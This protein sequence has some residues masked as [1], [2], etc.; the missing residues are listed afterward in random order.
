MASLHKWK[1][2]R[3]F[4]Y[5]KNYMDKQIRKKD[6]VKIRR[7][8]ISN[9]FT[10]EALNQYINI[11]NFVIKDSTNERFQK[12]SL[13]ATREQSKGGGSKAMFIY[14]CYLK[15]KCNRTKI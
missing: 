14:K 5:I 13:N 15:T 11:L 12:K 9:R 4:E 6:D 2:K 3:K 7:N 8:N 10:A 1:C